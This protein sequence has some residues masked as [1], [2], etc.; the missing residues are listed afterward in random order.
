MVEVLL[1]NPPESTNKY[2]TFLNVLAPPL[3]I[4]YIGAVLEE[5]GISVKIIDAPALRMSIDDVLGE[6]KRESPNLIGITCTT[7]IMPHVSKLMKR[8]REE[9]ID[10]PIVCGGNHP[11]FCDEDTLRSG[12]DFVVRGEG[13][14]TLLE[15]YRT[16]ENG[17]ELERVKGISFLKDGKLVRTEERE[18]I[19]DLD[20]LPFPA[21]H[22]LPMDRY[23]ALG[24]PHRFTTMI[25][26]RGCPM[27]CSF[28][29]SSAFHGR[30]LRIRSV[31]N[32]VDEVEHVIDEYGVEFITFMDD[33][34][35][36]LRNWVEKFC[37]EILR[38]GIEIKW[39]ATARVDRMSLDLLRKMKKSGCVAL[40]IGVESGDQEILDRIT[41]NVVLEQTKR[42]FENM[43]K[44]GIL[45][46][47]SVA[48]GYPGET[49]ESIK[50]TMRFIEEIKPDYFVASIAT[51][52][53]GTRFYDEVKEKGLIV[54]ER[55]EDFTLF[56]STIRCGELEPEELERLRYE[57]M[58]R[59][60]LRPMKILKM[61]IRDGRKSLS[62]IKHLA[63]AKLGS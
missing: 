4:A 23:Q 38:R 59:F 60:Y 27:G 13:E 43:R 44:A 51:P 56:K 49:R 2:R 41:K 6:I 14:I 21:R 24:L 50:R 30:K 28:C 22:L 47:A 11:T 61:L 45:S 18:K 55:W 33:T 37:D 31:E 58:K 29:A 5:N 10:A 25:A 32:V 20:S 46:I 52:Y 34:F 57:M 19:E 39:G 63:L 36:L 26:S 16:I 42:A 35:T 12:A 54:S 1:I 15:L 7:P 53:P 62:V 17:G 8:I 3:G 48:I 9:G 40:F